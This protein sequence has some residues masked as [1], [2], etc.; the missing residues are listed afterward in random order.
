MAKA[1]KQIIADVG[2]MSTKLRAEAS[3]TMD[4]FGAMAKAAMAEGALSMGAKELIAMAI[5][6]ATR[7]DGCIGYH[8]KA[9]VRLKVPRAQVVEMLAVATYMGGGPSLMY[10]ADALRAYEEFGGEAAT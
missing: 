3:G 9:L 1:Y 7:C 2:E 6:I 8:A 10:A 4:G 5:A